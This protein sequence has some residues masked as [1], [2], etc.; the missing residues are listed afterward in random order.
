[1]SPHRVPGSRCPRG[2]RL[3]AGLAFLAVTLAACGT[4]DLTAPGQYGPSLSA[5]P[6][7][8]F[9]GVPTM[10]T[11][12]L[13][14]APKAGLGPILVDGDGRTIY[15]FTADHGKTSTCYD[16]CARYW[17]P[18]TVE[19]PP[20]VTGGANGALVGTTTR[21]DGSTQLTYGGHPLYYY[22]FDDHDSKSI[23][24]EGLS[25]FGKKWSELGE[26]WYGVSPA[27]K[28]VLPGA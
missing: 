28:K 17:P 8:T 4:P 3:G 21:A 24:G 13:G 22:L 6:S 7:V 18:V 20:K 26:E 5:P 1:M 2:I 27:G 25:E 11:T 23:K 14:T 12:A 16:D 15:L 9:G 19:H 10:T